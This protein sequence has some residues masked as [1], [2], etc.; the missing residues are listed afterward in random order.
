MTPDFRIPLGDWVE[1][2]L[3]WL[4]T[5]L[6]GFF[7]FVRT[8]FVGAYDGLDWVLNAPPFWAIIL[9]FAAIA[10]W[11]SGWKLGVG[12]LLSFA[13]VAGV[14]QWENTMHSMALVVIATVVAVAIS[15]PLGIWAAS[16]LRVSAIIRP[17]MDFM[18][19]MP[20]MVYLIP[21]LVMFRVGV[22][23]GIIA[24]IIFAMAPGV[25]FTELGIRGVDKEVVEAG[26]AFGSSPGRILRQIQLPLA[27]PTIM[28]GVNQV[29]MLALSMVVIAGMVGAP[30][31]GSD[32]VAALSRIDAGLGFEAGIAVVILAIFLD[33][34]TASFGK[35]KTRS[36]AK[37]A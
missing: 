20:A 14:D 31:L 27:R 23:P 32:I 35:S 5:S 1:V 6:D 28:A 33:R 11:A 30:G 16:S 19:T 21:A 8:V 3:D 37:S 34:V 4:T 13:V 29:I 10:W 26:H 2:G 36:S 9:I 18:Q 12:T 22:V 7:K 24:T 25:R 17:I 15:V